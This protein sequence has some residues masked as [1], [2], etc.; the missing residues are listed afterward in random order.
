[1]TSSA[2]RGETTLPAS[3][4]TCGVNPVMSGAASSASDADGGAA[5]AVGNEAAGFNA[6]CAGS[7]GS[8]VASRGGDGGEARVGLGVVV[9]EGATIDATSADGV[10]SPVGVAIAVTLSRYRVPSGGALIPGRG[11]AVRARIATTR[12]DASAVS[13][14]PAEVAELHAETVGPVDPGIGA[15]PV[16]ASRPSVATSALEM[17]KP[18]SAGLADRA[19]GALVPAGFA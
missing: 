18:R 2:R 13:A 8:T 14:A 4:A 7:V 5:P 1:M 10:G 11:G 6:F 3:S 9:G 12:D 17:P 15:R 19:G 16:S